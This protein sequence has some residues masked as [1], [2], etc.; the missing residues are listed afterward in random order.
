[1]YTTLN[2]SLINKPFILVLFCLLFVLVYICL[3]FWKC[4]MYLCWYF[5]LKLYHISLFI[6][7]CACVCG[8]VQLCVCLFEIEYICE[9]FWEWLFPFVFQHKIVYC[10]FAY[11]EL[12]FVFLFNS[13]SICMWMVVWMFIYEYVYVIWNCIH[14]FVVLNYEF[15]CICIM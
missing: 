6:F 5:E 10:V 7:N 13:N 12:Y 15:E 4:F 14:V 1:M 11:L 2:I 9:W 3:W 8:S